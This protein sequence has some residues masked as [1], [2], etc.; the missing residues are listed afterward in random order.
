M[1]TEQDTSP[2]G[3]DSAGLALDEDVLGHVP[4]TG[5]HLEG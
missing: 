2:L 1:R 3:L 4:I 5:V